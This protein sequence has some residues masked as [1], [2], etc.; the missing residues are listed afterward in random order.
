MKNLNSSDFIDL[1]RRAGADPRRRCI[2]KITIKR[3]AKIGAAA[4]MLHGMAWDKLLG[5]ESLFS[6]YAEA[7][8]LNL[9]EES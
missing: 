8:N 4:V 9:Q 5:D 7:A 6:F 2:Y 1:T 3:A